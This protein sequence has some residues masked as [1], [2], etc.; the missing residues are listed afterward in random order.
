MVRLGYNEK[1]GRRDATAPAPGTGHVRVDPFHKVRPLG[2]YVGGIQS[3][4]VPKLPLHA[5]APALRVLRPVVG[6]GSTHQAG[7]IRE[8]GNAGDIK[9]IA[10]AAA[11]NDALR[12]GEL[13]AEAE[14]RVEREQR[15]AGA[16]VLYVRDGISAAQHGAAVAA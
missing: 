1:N 16:Q 14:R 11:G 10:Q 2:S 12:I 5:E 4:V 6:V 9:T 3:E 7:K 13:V 15:A 8:R